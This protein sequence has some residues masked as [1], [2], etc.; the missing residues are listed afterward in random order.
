[1]ADGH[2]GTGR[3]AGIRQRIRIPLRFADDYS[4]T[5]TIVSFTGL[6]DGQQHVAFELGRPG[7]AR[8]PLVRLHSECL[9]GDVFGSQRCDCGAQLREAVERIARRGGHDLLLRRLDGAAGPHRRT[10]PLAGPA[11][12]GFESR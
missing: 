2:R 12:L 6:A 10:G 4:T 9:T 1:V 8:L 3:G 11:D 5:A 7:Q